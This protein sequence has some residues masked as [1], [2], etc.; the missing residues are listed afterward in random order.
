LSH[1][2]PLEQFRLWLLQQ[3]SQYDAQA[4]GDTSSPLCGAS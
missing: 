3:A 2:K 4:I 1:S